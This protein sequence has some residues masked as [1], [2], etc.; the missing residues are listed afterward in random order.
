MLFFRFASLSHTRRAQ[1]GTQ[2]SHGAFPY[3]SI[4]GVNPLPHTGFGFG[5]Q[6]RERERK[7]RPL[8]PPLSY[9][10]SKFEPAKTLKYGGW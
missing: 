4:Y 9:T 3:S 5:L 6:T 7:G 2:I 10:A 8:D 1:K